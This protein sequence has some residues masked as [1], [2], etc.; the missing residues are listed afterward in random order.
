MSPPSPRSGSDSLSLMKRL[1]YCKLKF[2]LAVETLNVHLFYRTRL[3]YFT[4]SGTVPDHRPSYSLNEDPG[5][6]SDIRLSTVL[7]RDPMK[8]RG[9]GTC[10]KN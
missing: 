1:F 5:E 7:G 6:G 2:R 3:P 10:T 4:Q 8:Y 9:H